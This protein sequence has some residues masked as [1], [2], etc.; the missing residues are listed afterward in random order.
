MRAGLFGGTF[1]PF[2][3]GHIGIIEHVQKKYGLNKI[4]EIDITQQILPTLAITQKVIQEYGL[5]TSKIVEHFM[6]TS[7]PFKVKLLKFFFHKQ[8]NELKQIFHYYVQRTNPTYFCE[9]VE[10]LRLLFHRV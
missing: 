2:H 8:L 6:F 1:N 9:H 4:T 7:A 3:N 5:P 10:Y